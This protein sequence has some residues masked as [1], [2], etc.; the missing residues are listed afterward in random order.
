MVQE[1]EKIPLSKGVA[2]FSGGTL[3]SRILG[4][5]R[6]QVFAIFFGAGIFTD[7]FFAAFRIPNLLRDLFAEGVFS[8]AFIPTF[9]REKAQEGVKPAF[10]LANIVITALTILVS[11]ICLIGILLSP[12]IVRIMAPGFAENPGQTE[13]TVALARIMFPLLLFVSLA[14]AAM[15]ILNS[16]GRFGVPAL[17]PVMFNLSMI[18]CGIFL[19]PYVNPPIISMAI[20]VFIG[21]LGQFLFQIPALRK[22]GFRF[23]PKLNFKDYR[24]IKILKLMLPASIGTAGIQINIFV[25]TLLASL[26]PQGS[27]SYLNYGYRLMHLPLALFGVGVASVSLPRFSVEYSN[28]GV[29]GLKEEYLLAMRFSLFLILP[30]AFFILSTTYPIV[31]AIFQ[32]GKFRFE[33]TIATVNVLRIYA[34][35]LFAF[36]SVRITSQAFFSMQDTKTPMKVGLLAV[37]INIILNLILMHPFQYL[38]LA[39][40]TTIAGVVNMTVLISLLR[41]RLDG[42]GI[43][44]LSTFLLKAIAINISLSVVAYYICEFKDMNTANVTALARIV[45]LM[46]IFVGYA[47]GYL[48]LSKILKIDEAQKVIEIFRTKKPVIR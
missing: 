36:A 45:W 25:A 42:L 30:A 3:V 2:R 24:L 16:F 22:T 14:S 47:T 10:E 39:A 46:V 33:D 28:S 21:G 48:I 32:H 37:V 41:I 7:A 4:L 8:A 43:K 29:S 11:V 5:V 38:G 44:S 18:F 27:I 1:K 20:G 9:S 26:L 19:R 31:G 40:A 12:L 17:A 15:G 35:G 23:R 13:L 6:E 34:I